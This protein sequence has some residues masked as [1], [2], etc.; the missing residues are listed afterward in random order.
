MPL[1]V[2]ICRCTSINVMM[3]AYEVLTVSIGIIWSFMRNVKIHI[4]SRILIVLLCLVCSPLIARDL[5]YVASNYPPWHIHGEV[6]TGIDPIIVKEL[7]KRLGLTPV[8]NQCPFKR[9]LRDL[10]NG[11]ADLTL[12]LNKSPDREAFLHFIEPPYFSGVEHVFYLPKGQGHTIQKFD[13]LYMLD[14]VAMVR[15]GRYF[16]QFDNDNRIRK[17][18]FVASEQMYKLLA[19][20]RISAFVG[21]NITSDYTISMLG[22]DHEFDKS[23]LRIKAPPLY[24]AISRKSSYVP[25][26]RQFSQAIKEMLDNGFIERAVRRY[27][28]TGNDN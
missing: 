2:S 17:T 22:F 4:Y 18:P 21:S 12:T 7:A 9:C 23:T 8:L 10:K 14:S 5:E 6:M 26:L 15:G 28:K 27:T 3:A 20:G 25:Y 16:P 1:K 11:T 19:K 24:L 13:D